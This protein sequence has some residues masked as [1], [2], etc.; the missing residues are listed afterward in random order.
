MT[1]ELDAHDRIPRRDFAPEPLQLVP[2]KLEERRRNR[3]PRNSEGA[4][5]AG[6][7]RTRSLVCGKGSGAHKR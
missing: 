5:N 4:G 6:R 1:T 3:V 7:W 2:P